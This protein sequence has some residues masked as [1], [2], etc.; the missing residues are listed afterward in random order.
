MW[1]LIF[2]SKLFELMTI[3][4]LQNVQLASIELINNTDLLLCP[5]HFQQLSCPRFGHNNR[6]LSLKQ[7][8]RTVIMQNSGLIICKV[9]TKDNFRAFNEIGRVSCYFK[10]YFCVSYSCHVDRAPDKG[11]MR[12]VCHVHNNGVDP[13]A[14]GAGLGVSFHNKR[15]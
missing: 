15:Q 14:V 9:G 1:G 13:L 2:E 7:L 6:V 4:R 3:N 12:H 10:I 11:R 8:F 5:F